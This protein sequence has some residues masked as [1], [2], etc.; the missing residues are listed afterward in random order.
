[1]S[2]RVIVGVDLGGTNVKTAMVSWDK[3]VLA[4]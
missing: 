2:S 1:M 3:Q 4:K